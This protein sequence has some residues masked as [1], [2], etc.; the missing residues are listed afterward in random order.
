MTKFATVNLGRQGVSKSGA[1]IASFGDQ[2]PDVIA[3]QELDI[4]RASVDRYVQ[5]WR[6]RGFDC[7]IGS[8]EVPRVAIVSQAPLFKVVPCGLEDEDRV[9]FACCEF[10]AGGSVQKILFASIYGHAFDSDLASALVRS[11]VTVA[12]SFG[13]P[14]MLFGDFNLEQEFDCFA[15]VCGAGV[16]TCLDSFFGPVAS[17]PPTRTGGHRRI[18]FGLADPR[19]VPSTLLHFPPVADHLAVCY[20]FRDLVKLAR[21]RGPPRLRSTPLDEEVIASRFAQHWCADRFNAFLEQGAVD[22]AWMALS[23]AAEYAIA[24][25]GDQARSQLSRVVPRAAPWEPSTAPPLSKAAVSEEPV[26]LRRLRRLHRRLLQLRMTPDDCSLRRAAVR[27]LVDLTAAVPSLSDWRERTAEG[28]CDKVQLAIQDMSEAI[29][30]ANIDKWR[31]DITLHPNKALT[32]IKKRAAREFQLGIQPEPCK[33]SDPLPAVH[34]AAVIQEA[35]K[36]WVDRW[37]APAPTLEALEAILTEDG[38]DRPAATVPIQ[39]QGRDFAAAA[40]AMKHKAAGPDDWA[41]K[42]VATLP[43]AWFAELA[44]LWQVV[45]QTSRIPAAWRRSRIALIPKVDG[46]QRPLAIA[47]VAWRLGAQILVRQLASWTQSWASPHLMGGLPGRSVAHAHVRIRE[48]ISADPE[49]I[50]VAQDLSKCFDSISIEHACRAMRHFGAPALFI[51]LVRQFYADQERI[52]S[53]DGHLGRGF[54]GVSRGIL[55]GC[56]LSPV[57]TATLLQCW[58]NYVCKP[59]CNIDCTVYVD[60]RTLWSE[61]TGCHQEA[62]AAAL[63]RSAHFD[64][65]CGWTCRASKCQLACRSRARCLELIQSTGYP[66]SESFTVLGVNYRFGASCSPSRISL[67]ELKLRARFLRGLHLPASVKPYLVRNLIMAKLGWIAAVTTDIDIDL[68][69]LRSEILLALVG[70]VACRDCSKALVFEIFGW[71][72]DPS[73]YVQWAAISAA[74]HW[75][76]H[77]PGWIDQVCMRFALKSWPQLLPGAV[78]VM[79]RWR[80]QA[81]RDGAFILRRDA[82]GDERRFECGV[83]GLQCLRRWLLHEHRRVAL[84]STGRI[85]HSLHRPDN[86]SLAQGL[87]L[88][89]PEPHQVVC[90]EAHRKLYFEKGASRQQR[91]VCVGSGC[92]VWFENTKHRRP[93]DQ[94]HVRCFC[95]LE[96]PS[97]PHLVYQCSGTAEIRRA[98]G[99]DTPVNRAEERLFAVVI[100]ELPHAP[101]AEALDVARSRVVRELVAAVGLHPASLL[102]ATDGSAKE[103]VAGWAVAVEG[104]GAHAGILAGEDHDSFLT[105]TFGLLVLFQALAEVADGVTLPPVKVLCDC[106]SALRLCEVE[107]N[108]PFLVQARRMQG[109]LNALRARDVCIVCSWV[110]AHGRH[111]GEWSPPQG[112]SGDRARHLNDVADQSACELVAEVWSGS[113]RALWHRDFRAACARELRFLRTASE[114]AAKYHEWMA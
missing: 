65:A 74:V 101:I 102:C 66:F 71:Q 95:D 93:R 16:A 44:R 107:Y 20:E 68:K 40:R 92:S 30:K 94:W 31:E 69:A 22:D 53:L 103:D 14:W 26:L 73:F 28:I 87:L 8:G 70:D 13:L 36:E 96:F 104:A 100:P 51:E 34:P 11:T 111:V 79:R 77:M 42:D 108:G 3:L 10:Q 50:V 72:C 112:V 75:Q 15:C 43:E 52:F 1:L 89:S 60:D 5:D 61:G 58:V 56:P 67:E 90:A 59:G 25:S 7:I 24:D 88:P 18:D 45:W 62:M 54:H 81:S 39:W 12:C 76:V 4:N 32:W 55:Q 6:R 41:P 47:S 85:E 63:R 46:T 84:A 23:E 57:I 2:I 82:R 27:A 98:T 29:K 105:E 21:L 64:Y 19:L 113:A 48:A 78:E 106:K 83:D 110:P 9:V 38:P 33:P 109:A 91:L 114:V 80:W 99:V 35:E 49:R 37:N 17:L 97:R 86:D